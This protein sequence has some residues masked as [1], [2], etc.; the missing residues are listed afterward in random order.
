VQM[1]VSDF[2]YEL[3]S[4]LIAQ[5]AIEPR[6]NSR[7][8]DTSTMR[9]MTF[10]ELPTLL[11]EGDLLVVN[12]TRVRAA[13]LIGRRDTGGRTEVL[14]TSRIDP[15]RWQ[16]LIKPARKV[17]VGSTITF[18]GG[19]SS[20][21]LSDPV[22]GVATVALIAESDVEDA[23]ES[24]GSL[25]LPPYFHGTLESE[26]RYQTVFAQHV[27]SAAAPTA[28]LHFSDQ[29]LGSLDAHG[30][31]V[32]AVDLEV[33]LDT[34]RPMDRGERGAGA[35]ADHQIHTEKV[36]VP[37]ETVEAVAATRSRGGRVVAVGTTV[38]RSLESAA[39]TGGQIASYDGET[40]L[41]ITPGYMPKVIDAV[42]TNFHAPGTTLL[43]LIA[44]LLG[45][46]WRA[47]YDHAMISGYRF[48][49]FGDAMYIEV[50]R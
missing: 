4:S 24:A 47:V 42:V 8:L 45:P 9:D 25:P 3:P 16:A 14:L 35:I 41:F 6:H 44:A 32:A 22:D 27:G 26:D 1:L 34:F 50:Q 37:A 48:L 40:D 12:N 13:R 39:T 21:V 49:S 46:G 23:I 17:R 43:V 10:V 5:D 30:V 18:P 31:S 7:L 29:L 11:D 2:D 38:V 19:L 20:T 28:A 33:G 15:E 36:T